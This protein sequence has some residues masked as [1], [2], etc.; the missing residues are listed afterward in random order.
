MTVSDVFHLDDP[1]EKGNDGGIRRGDGEHHEA[2]DLETQPTKC[3]QTFTTSF[4]AGSL[5][6]KGAKGISLFCGTD[7]IINGYYVAIVELTK[8]YKQP[9]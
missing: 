6:I 3:R 9:L 5:V 1:H 7:Q 2:N 8:I 4:D